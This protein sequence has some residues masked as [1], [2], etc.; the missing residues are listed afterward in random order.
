MLGNNLRKDLQV[1]A[2]ELAV[3]E[4]AQSSVDIVELCH[5]GECGAESIWECID[6]GVEGDGSESGVGCAPHL[7]I[8]VLGSTD[9]EASA[10]EGVIH[11]LGPA[12][13]K[14]LTI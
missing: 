14:L 10:V 5:L 12:V 4:P 2:G 13:G 8:C 11:W 6:V 7:V 1:Y 9:A 3:G